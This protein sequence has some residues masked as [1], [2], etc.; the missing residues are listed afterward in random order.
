MRNLHSVSNTPYIT[1]DCN[2]GEYASGMP[3]IAEVNKAVLRDLAR[4]FETKYDLVAAEYNQICL[5][6][7]KL[8]DEYDIQYIAPSEGRVLAQLALFAHALTQHEQRKDDYSLYCQRRSWRRD[9]V[10][11]VPQAVALEPS[12]STVFTYINLN[13]GKSVVWAH[14]EM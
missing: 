7:V 13:T 1:Y 9:E 11:V 10:T 3:N 5:Q 12:L 14:V 6:G 2:G 4:A 8:V